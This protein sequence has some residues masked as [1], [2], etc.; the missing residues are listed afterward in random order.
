MWEL[1]GPI[2]TLKRSNTLIAKKLTS[3]VVGCGYENAGAQNAPAERSD[4]RVSLEL[5][6]VFVCRKERSF[7]LNLHLE[8]PVC[9]WV[10][11]DGA[12]VVFK[13]FVDLND[14]TG[15]G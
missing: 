15:D 3:S 12:R 9:V 7:A 10:F 11:V 2:P 1:E 8:E 4:S 13:V 5:C 6:A 14:F